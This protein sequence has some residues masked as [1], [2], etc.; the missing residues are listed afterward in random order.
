MV[1]A[2]VVDSLASALRERRS[3]L[4]YTGNNDGEDGIRTRKDRDDLSITRRLVAGL[5]C[6]SLLDLP[7]LFRCFCKDPSNDLSRPGFT[8]AGFSQLFPV[9]APNLLSFPV[10]ISK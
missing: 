10:K 6:A 8:R 5:K 3:T 7:W 2:R 1:P 4:S 9:S